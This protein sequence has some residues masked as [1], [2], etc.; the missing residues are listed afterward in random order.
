MEEENNKIAKGF[1]RDI[2]YLTIKQ[3]LLKNL[4]ELCEKLQ[5]KQTGYEIACTH[6][7][8]AYVIVALIQLKNGSRISEACSA[9][10]IFLKEFVKNKDFNEKVVVKI[11]KSAG[12]KYNWQ[13]K[14]KKISKARFRKMAFPTWINKKFID[15][16]VDS[17]AISILVISKR[18]KKRVLDYLLRYFN[19]NTHSLRY[20]CINYLLNEQKLQMNIVAKFVG[21]TNVSQ[22]VTYTQTKNTDKIFDLDI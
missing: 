15:I 20:A 13:T 2:D 17:E 1:D 11:A 7:Q 19:C 5:K 9:F 22:L 4:D 21:H 12:V 3:K 10:R 6:N 18:L 16:I 14:N 8:I